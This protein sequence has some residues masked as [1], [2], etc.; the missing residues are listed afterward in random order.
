MCLFAFYTFAR[1]GEITAPASGTTIYL[2][3]VS[4]LLNDKQEDEAFKVTFLNY[5]HNT[6]NL[7]FASPFLI[8]LLAARCKIYWL[9]CKH[10]DTTL[11]L[12][13]KCLMAL[14][15]PA[16]FSERSF[17][18]FCSLDPTRYKGHSFRMGA[19]THAADKGMSNVQIRTM[20]H[21]RSNVF[22]KY[23]RLQSMSI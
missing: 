22:L 1:V 5:R 4:K 9:I 10:E 13:F 20:G 3:Q 12:F 8:K 19:A 11:G 16:Q 2:H 6:T 15:S 7:C 17:L 14:L 23:I 18:K 21:W